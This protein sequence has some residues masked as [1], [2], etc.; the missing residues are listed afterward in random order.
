ME[1]RNG[2]NIRRE[3]RGQVNRFCGSGKF[4][5]GIIIDIHLL[6]KYNGVSARNIYWNENHV[7]LSIYYDNK[8]LIFFIR[9][10]LC[11]LL[12]FPVMHLLDS[13]RRK[14]GLHILNQAT[15]VSKFVATRTSPIWS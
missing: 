11:I 2:E 14:L 5:G 6:I 7:N 4:G 10:S 13:G 1:E 12:T 8:N 15:N 3:L 9:E